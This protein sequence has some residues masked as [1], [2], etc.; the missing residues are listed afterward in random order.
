MF[1][2]ILSRDIFCHSVNQQIVRWR[3]YAGIS[4]PCCPIIFNFNCI[5]HESYALDKILLRGG[6][7]ICLSGDQRITLVESRGE[8]PCCIGIQIQL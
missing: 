4:I 1:V 2:T 6:G 5:F 7:D 8:Y 3:P